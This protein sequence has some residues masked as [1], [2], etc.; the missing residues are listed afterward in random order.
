VL[1]GAG[2][3][4]FLPQRAPSFA[5]TLRRAGGDTEIQRTKT[6][7][8][9]PQRSLWL[10]TEALFRSFRVFRGEKDR[11]GTPPEGGTPNGSAAPP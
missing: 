11:L 2:L 10:R 3:G 9:V 1:V 6:F 7:S 5:D 8:S 4:V